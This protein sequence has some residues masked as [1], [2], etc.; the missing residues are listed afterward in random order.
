MA[1]KMPTMKM[2][3]FLVFARMFVVG[4]VG[5]ETLRVTFY[6]GTTFAKQL[7]PVNTNCS[8][9]IMRRQ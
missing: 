9:L 2:P 8:R 7:G 1:T 6:L 3:E 4:F 5:A